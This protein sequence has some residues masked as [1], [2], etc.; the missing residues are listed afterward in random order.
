[1]RPLEEI[2]DDPMAATISE[3]LVLVADPYEHGLFSPDDTG[4]MAESVFH[5]VGEG[6]RLVPDFAAELFQISGQVDQ[7]S[8]QEVNNVL[9]KLGVSLAHRPKSFVEQL[10]K[11]WRGQRNL[12]GVNDSKIA[13]LAQKT[14]IDADVYRMARYT[15]E[16]RE[17]V[18]KH[19]KSTKIRQMYAPFRHLESIPEYGITL[20]LRDKPDQGYPFY[21]IWGWQEKRKSMQRVVDKILLKIFDA[22]E[23]ARK[24]KDRSKFYEA[25]FGSDYFGVKL[26]GTSSSVLTL[27]E[28]LVYSPTSIWEVIGKEDYTETK[29]GKA[30]RAHE[31]LLKPRQFATTESLQ[32]QI[33]PLP[34]FFLDEFFDRSSHPLYRVRRDRQ[35]QE[36]KKKHPRMYARMESAI[37]GVLNFPQMLPPNS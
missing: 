26:I 30:L 29:K 32:V 21:Q 36:Y 16:W 4:K 28:G 19:K 33:T 3:I 7:F 18:E 2:A 1:M 13:E 22:M 34:G 31:Y 9:E 27:M 25:D 20:R 35:L 6:V 11:A 17:N 5:K 8:H 23:T 12:K 14:G 15:H 37:R 24:Q 10:K